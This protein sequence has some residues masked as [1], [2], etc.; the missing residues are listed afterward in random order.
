MSNKL[1]GIKCNFQ[2]RK[3]AMEEAQ[4]ELMEVE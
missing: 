2:N 1:L 3:I 4:I